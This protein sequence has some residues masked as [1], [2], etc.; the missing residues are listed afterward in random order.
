MGIDGGI[1]SST[2]QVLVLAVRD[3]EVRLRV[4]ILLGQ[5]EIDDVDLVTTL[6]NAHQ[7]VVGFD[8]TMDEGLGVD[9]LDAGDELVGEKQNGLQGE[10]AV[11]EVEEVFERRAKQVEDH[12]IVVTL[13][14]EPTH[15]GYADATGEGFVDT[16]LIFELWM[17]GFDGLEFDRDFLSGY[18][19]CAYP[20]LVLR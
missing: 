7:E 14:T 18:D 15:E 4:T 13:G 10:L 9:V 5:T 20:K 17:L 16:S 11:A 19:V 1:T 6:A 2:G 3:V 12:R 8:I